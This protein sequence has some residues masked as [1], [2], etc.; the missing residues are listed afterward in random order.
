MIIVAVTGFSGSQLN[1]QDSTDS[2]CNTN[3][4]TVLLGP[5]AEGCTYK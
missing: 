1:V 3:G 2:E 4:E 5:Y